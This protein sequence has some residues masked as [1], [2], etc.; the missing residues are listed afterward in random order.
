[1]EAGREG[2]FC[3]TL[4]SAQT[5]AWGAPSVLVRRIWYLTIKLLW[6]PVHVYLVFFFFIIFSLSWSLLLQS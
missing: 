1:M 2:V 5:E 3:D 4:E 6:L